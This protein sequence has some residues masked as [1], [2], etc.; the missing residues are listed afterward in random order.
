MCSFISKYYRNFDKDHFPKWIVGDGHQNL[1][2]KV[3]IELEQEYQEHRYVIIKS[4]VI[5]SSVIM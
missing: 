4:H 3:E 2:R 5:L 1:D